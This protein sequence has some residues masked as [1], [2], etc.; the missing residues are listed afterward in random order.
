LPTPGHDADREPV[1]IRH[2]SPYPQSSRARERERNG[3]D[4]G[5]RLALESLSDEPRAKTAKPEEFYDDT[6]LRSLEQ[7]G[8]FRQLYR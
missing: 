7:E 1:R 4:A 8:F 5:I 3:F 2:V 6:I